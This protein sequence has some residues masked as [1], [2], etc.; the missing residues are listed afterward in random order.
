MN[1]L[2]ILHKTRNGSFVL[3]TGGLLS[4]IEKELIW[5][6]ELYYVVHSTMNCF[7]KCNILPIMTL[8]HIRY[9]LSLI[10]GC[11]IVLYQHINSI[12]ERRAGWMNG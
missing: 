8:T 4:L 2:F 1:H 10:I 3:Y 11:L 6:E 7:R 5:L 12:V 9:L